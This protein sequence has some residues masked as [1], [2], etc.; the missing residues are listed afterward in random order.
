MAQYEHSFTV[1]REIDG[2]IIEFDLI[3]EFEINPLVRGQYYGAPEN[4]YPD[5]VGEAYIDGD[6]Y[7]VD[8]DDNRVVWD[9][10]LTTQE[11][12]CICQAAYD[13]WQDTASEGVCA[14]DDALLDREYDFFHDERAIS[15]SGRGKVY[16]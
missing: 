3:A 15:L 8:A 12:E 14:D 9:G 13:A 11:E 5:E 16:Y 10:K 4:C 1:E 7:T 2:E 6:V